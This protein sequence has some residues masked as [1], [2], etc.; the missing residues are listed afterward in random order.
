[1]QVGNEAQMEPNEEVELEEFAAVVGAFRDQLL[2]CLEE[3]A[4]GRHGLFAT[5][6]T[7]DPENPETRPW[8]EAE[9][10]R[11]LA[12]A[13]QGLLAQV[14]ERDALV[15]E[16]LDLCT[17]HGESDPGERRLARV[18]LDRIENGQVGSESRE[19]RSRW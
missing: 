1:M 17:I 15:D 6:A 10:L 3:C 7:L 5:A 18:F 16:F 9:R 13:L 12:M 19:E 2:A 11:E 4:R 8:P 14:E